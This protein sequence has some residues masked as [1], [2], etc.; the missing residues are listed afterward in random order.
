MLLGL[1]DLFGLPCLAHDDIHIS[2]I[3]RIP[4]VCLSSDLSS[5][6]VKI[7]LFSI[8]ETQG[9]SW[10]DFH[11]LRIV[12]TN[13]IT[14]PPQPPPAPYLGTFRLVLVCV[15]CVRRR[16]RE[17]A[18]PWRECNIVRISMRIRVLTGKT[19]PVHILERFC[20]ACGPWIDVEG[21]L[22]AMRLPDPSWASES[23]QRKLDTA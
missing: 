2:H 6:R 22:A 15:R 1:L 8:F 18:Q 10:L 4:L 5:L 9:Q 11:S 23:I 14:S 19:W 16:C 3:K 7:D 17:R 20:G 13:S 12:S 21:D